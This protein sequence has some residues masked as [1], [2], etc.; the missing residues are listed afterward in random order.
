MRPIW[1]SWLPVAIV[2]SRPD[3]EDCLIEMPLVSLH[4]EL[5]SPTD[6]LDVVGPIELTDHVVTKQIA[7]T[8]RRDSPALSILGVGPEQVTHRA[9]VGNL[10]LPVDGSDLVEGLDAGT[11]AAVNTEDL[12][13]YDGWEGEIVEYLC[14]V[15]PDRDTPVLPE[16]LVIEPVHLGDLSALVV[17][18]D[19]INPV[20]VANLQG[21]QQ[22]EGFHTVESAVHE[23]SHEEIVRVGNIAAHL[24]GV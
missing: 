22:Q 18:S 7:G 21:Q 12:A 19:Q 20:R 24:A 1:L 10:L 15:S 3:G 6:H 8:S 17:S 23:I 16:T 11:E 2:G 14:A 5:V 9:I 4:D 13:V